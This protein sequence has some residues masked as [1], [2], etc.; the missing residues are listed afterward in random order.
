MKGY[1]S[2]RMERDDAFLDR[3]ARGEV[4]PV[5]VELRPQSESLVDFAHPENAL[6]VFGP[7]DGSIP[8]GVLARCHRFVVIPTH[9]CLNLSA[10]VN[11]VLYDRRAKRIAA[12]LEPNLPIAELLREHRGY[13]D[14]EEVLGDAGG[15]RRG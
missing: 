14:L 11:L 3:Y 15:G 4:T 10:A 12:G 8:K 7:E 1:R 5:A 9:H 13:L 2:V 6:Y